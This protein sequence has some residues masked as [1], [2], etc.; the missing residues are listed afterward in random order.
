MNGRGAWVS[1]W[2]RGFRVGNMREEEPFEWCVGEVREERYLR[3]SERRAEV[4][5]TGG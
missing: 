2:V 4:G 5:E 3:G 1:A